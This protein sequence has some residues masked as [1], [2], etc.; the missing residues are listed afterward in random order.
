[1]S[2]VF[3]GT[4][5]THDWLMNMKCALSKHTNPI[6][7]AY[8]HREVLFGLHTGYAQ[9]MLRK[10]KDTQLTQVE[11]IMTKIHTIGSE[12]VPN[13]NYKL[14]ITGHSLGG[15]LAT[16]LA[17]YAASSDMLAKVKT[18]RAF[19]FAAPRVGKYL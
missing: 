8:P 3:R 9:L 13:G 7:E 17:F 10:R 4:V 16:L 5:S 12:L 1:M 6:A 18:I 2:V 19:T 15:A 11:E 14:S